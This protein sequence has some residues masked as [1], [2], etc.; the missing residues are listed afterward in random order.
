MKMRML[1][2]SLALFAHSHVQAPQWQLV[3]MLPTPVPPSNS[4]NAGVAAMKRD[5][6]KRRNI[7]K[8]GL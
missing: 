8:R 6:K 7:K 5:A 1:A 4:R 3:G 2:A